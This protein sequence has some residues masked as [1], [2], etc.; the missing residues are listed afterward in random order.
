MAR[1]EVERLD[2]MNRDW[3]QAF[4]HSLRLRDMYGKTALDYAEQGGYDLIVDSLRDA[5]KRCVGH[6]PCETR[7][8]RLL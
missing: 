7:M 3:L 8:Y 6:A 5:E 4:K 1:T 2:L